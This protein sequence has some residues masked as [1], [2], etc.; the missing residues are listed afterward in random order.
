MT[1]P[2][3]SITLFVIPA[4]TVTSKP[5]APTGLA[6]SVGSGT[7]TVTWIGSGGATSYT[8]RR[9]SKSGSG[10]VSLVLRCRDST[11]RR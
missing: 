11:R 6:A 10:Y 8:V 4:G 9:S 1:L 3:Q 7:V 2:S 5:S